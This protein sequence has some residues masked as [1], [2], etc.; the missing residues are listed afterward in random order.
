V[1]L[2]LRFLEEKVFL[3]FVLE[4]YFCFVKLDKNNF[5]FQS[6]SLL[7]VPAIKIIGEVCQ[8]PKKSKAGLK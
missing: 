3:Y 1:L 8:H 6:K 7:F 5:Y 2:G 4:N